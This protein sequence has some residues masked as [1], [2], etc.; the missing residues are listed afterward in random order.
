MREYEDIL[1]V[2]KRYKTISQTTTFYKLTTTKMIKVE[3]WKVLL[4]WEDIT[5]KPVWN[6]I[7]CAWDHYVL[8]RPSPHEDR[9][10]WNCIVSESDGDRLYYRVY[11]HHKE[12]AYCSHRK[13]AERVL[14]LCE[15]QQWD[16]E[17]C[18]E[19]EFYMNNAI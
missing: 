16:A 14:D 18:K 10:E 9:S 3:N 19:D 8:L 12:V 5:N 2:S 7:A 13:D 6:Y 17:H 1:R 4:D 11:W 15:Q